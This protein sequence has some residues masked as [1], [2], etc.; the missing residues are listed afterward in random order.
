MTMSVRSVG[1]K[2]AGY[3]VSAAILSALIIVASTLYLGLP[4][5][6]STSAVPTGSTYSIAG[7]QSLLVVQL[8]DP[9]Q[10][11]L[12]TRSLN[13]TDSSIALV[14]GEP[15]GSG[16][17]NPTTVTVTPASGT[18]TL[19]LLR[20]QNVSQTIAT[21]NL[22]NGSTIYSVTFTVSSIS[23]NVNG[24]VSPVTLA[25]GGNAFSV[26][27]AQPTSLQG[28]NVALLQLNP[29]VVGTPSGYQLI[30][31]AVG[32]IKHFEGQGQE[33][34]GFQHTL[35]HNDT[36]ELQNAKG[37]LTANLL[38]LSVSGNTTSVTVQVKNAGSA[39]VTLNAIGLQGNFTTTGSVCPVSK[40]QGFEH[41]GC[42]MPER[43]NEVVFVPVVPTA[44]STATSTTCASG[45][46]NLISG[47]GE[48][49]GH[50]RGYV[51]QAGQCVNFAFTGKITFGESGNVL[52]PSAANGQTYEVHVIGSEGANLQLTCT[53]PLGATSCKVDKHGWF[54]FVIPFR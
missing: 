41:H 50:D 13:L 39:A 44:S 37:N 16:K 32:V 52:V 19:N 29:I 2:T 42:E 36:G 9:P 12:G 28:E 53:L 38:T 51:L 6:T 15:S 27:I 31:S 3:V 49:Q 43:M 22:P 8:T 23:I 48:N 18:A 34:V 11:P 10:V 30:P 45:Q 33:Q 46:M 40:G 35:S 54:D 25:T 1:K 26:T 17:V 7:P 4:V 5:L 24:T 14:V 47:D 20:L 21:T